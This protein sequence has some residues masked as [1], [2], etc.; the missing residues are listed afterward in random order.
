MRT[1]D[2]PGD[3]PGV[4]HGLELL[5][6]QAYTHICVHVCMSSGGQSEKHQR[7]EAVEQS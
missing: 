5:V 7:P 1:G 4:K 3:I 2:K 6:R